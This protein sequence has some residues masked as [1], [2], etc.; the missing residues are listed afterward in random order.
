MS[1][2]NCDA[3]TSEL[4]DDL[5]ATVS[6]IENHDKRLNAAGEAISGLLNLIEHQEKHIGSMAK[7]TLI[8]Y[9]SLAVQAVV[10]IKFLF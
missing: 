9:V 10:L 2:S 4:R 8:L 1:L 7:H 3:S 6:V 5:R